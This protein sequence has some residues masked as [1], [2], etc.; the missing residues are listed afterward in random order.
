MR[1]VI[2]CLIDWLNKGPSD[3]KSYRILCA[4][5]NESFKKASFGENKRHFTADDLV[6]AAEETP[7]SAD[8]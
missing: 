7:K 3:E 4:V 5:A 8:A 1:E 2:Q 6:G